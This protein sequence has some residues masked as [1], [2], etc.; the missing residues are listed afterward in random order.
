VKQDV[1]DRAIRILRQMAAADAEMA[2]LAR[3][4]GAG[5]GGAF[6]EELARLWRA[7]AA[8]V[9]SGLDATEVAAR[10]ERD[11]WPEKPS[12]LTFWGNLS[13]RQE[14]GAACLICGVDISDL[15]PGETASGEPSAVINGKQMFIHRDPTVC[16]RALAAK[17][18]QEVPF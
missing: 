8:A 16:T 18:E 15:Y 12:V 1:K 17:L 13:A 7:L 11:S 6:E 9:E 4:L 2:E 3:Q 10:T 14:A 5:G